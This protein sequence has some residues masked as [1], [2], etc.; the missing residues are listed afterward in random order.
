[1]DDVDDFLRQ[2]RIAAFECP[3][4][5]EVPLGSYWL[6]NPVMHGPWPAATCAAVLKIW[7]EADLIRL[8]FPA[9]PA[10]W[11]LVPGG[12]GTRLVD[13]DALADADAE[14]LLDHPE[15]WVRENADGY[16]VPCATWQG[17]VAPLAEWLAAALDTAQRLPLTTH[18]E[19]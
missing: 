3:P 17:D 9:Y 7:Y 4:L 11:N 14:K 12:W 1:M 10:E 8:H 2:L 13:G 5:C 18:P 19:P 6:G 16:V 15:R